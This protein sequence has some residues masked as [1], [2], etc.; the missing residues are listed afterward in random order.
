LLLNLIDPLHPRQI[1]GF[2]A[3][4]AGKA[5]TICAFDWPLCVTFNG[6]QVALLHRGE[7]F[8]FTPAPLWKRLIGVRWTITALKVTGGTAAPARSS[9]SSL[10]Q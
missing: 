4:E 2:V 7:R 9:E 6:R 5:A 3:L 8:A 1:P 10:R